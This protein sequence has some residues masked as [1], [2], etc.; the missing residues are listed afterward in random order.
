MIGFFSLNASRNKLVDLPNW[1]GGLVHLKKWETF[2]CVSCF[3]FFNV[4]WTWA[5][6]ILRVFQ[7]AL[8]SWS[9]WNGEIEMHKSLFFIL[10]QLKFGREPCTGGSSKLYRTTWTV[11][12]VRGTETS[13]F[14]WLIFS[15]CSLKARCSALQILPNWIGHLKQLT[16]WEMYSGFEVVTRFVSRLDLHLSKLTR[17]SDGI[18]DLKQLT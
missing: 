13:E 4:V 12:V 8:V 10:F 15:S 11:V 17:L 18:R 9:S 16:K 7:I 1:I 3:N 2:L 14:A 5:S 6:I